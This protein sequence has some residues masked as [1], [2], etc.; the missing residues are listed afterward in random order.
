MIEPSLSKSFERQTGRKRAGL[1]ADV[2]IADREQIAS[3]GL[4]VERLRAEFLRGAA[5]YTRLFAIAHGQYAERCGKAR[6]GD[7][8]PL[9]ERHADEI[10]AGYPGAKFLHLVRDPRD[11]FRAEVER[12]V[13]GPGA[14]G[15]T[16]A[17]WVRS[18]HFAARNAERYPESYRVVR[19]ESLVTDPAAAVRSVCEFLGEPFVPSML[20]MEGAHRY[21]DQRATSPGGDPISAAFV[22]GY[23]SGIDRCDLAFIQAIAGRPMRRLGYQLDAIRLTPAER[24]RGAAVWPLGITRVGA[25][26]TVDVVHA[27]RRTPVGIG[28]AVR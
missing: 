5:T 10:I 6:W 9:N 2:A 27:R 17:A 19:Y 22:G 13:R 21:D 23:R 7:Q 1:G 25:R 15:P 4:D 8:S 18:T 3:L 28:G 14:V 26:R 11:C 20:A 16:T 12:G 24:M